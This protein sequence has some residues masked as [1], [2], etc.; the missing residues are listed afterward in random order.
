MAI[1][2]TCRVSKEER[3]IFWEVILSAILSRK[4]VYVS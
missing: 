2:I 3:S 1:V 4:S